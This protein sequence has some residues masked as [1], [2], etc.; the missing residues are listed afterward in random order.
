MSP[1]NKRLQ[2]P[3][4]FYGI[5]RGETVFRFLKGFRCSKILRREIV[6]RFLRFFKTGLRSPKMSVGCGSCQIVV[7]KGFFAFQHADLISVICSPF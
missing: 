7:F 1:K 4:F 3:F 6:F 2:L 5:L